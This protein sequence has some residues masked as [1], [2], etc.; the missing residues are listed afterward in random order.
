MHIP[1]GPSDFYIDSSE[2]RIIMVFGSAGHGKSTTLNALG[3]NF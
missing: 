3:A 2:H 1:K